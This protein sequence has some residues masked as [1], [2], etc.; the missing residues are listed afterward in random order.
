MQGCSKRDAS[1]IFHGRL[2]QARGL[3]APVKSRAS[4]Q[5]SPKLPTA[6][7]LSVSN[8]RG[9]TCGFLLSSWSS[10]ESRRPFCQYAPSFLSLLVRP[11]VIIIKKLST[12][13]QRRKLLRGTTLLAAQFA[14][15]FVQTPKDILALLSVGVRPSLLELLFFGL[16]TLR[17]VH[18]FLQRCFPPTSSSLGLPFCATIPLHRIDQ[19]FF[20]PII[21][22]KAKFCQAKIFMLFLSFQGEFSR[23]SMYIRT[24]L[25]WI[26]AKKGSYFMHR[27]EG[28]L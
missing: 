24:L 25:S 14:A 6:F 23:V 5:P 9:R 11:Y 27:K 20:F 3:H 22:A 12:L 13:L 17:R 21:R 28:L 4:L 1:L 10:S 19:N 18:T 2:C 26:A 15:C 16:A 7:L 8:P